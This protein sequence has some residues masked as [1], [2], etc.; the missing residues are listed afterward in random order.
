[1]ALSNVLF[2]CLQVKGLETCKSYVFRVRA[3]NASGIGVASTPSDP[4]CIKA[5]PGKAVL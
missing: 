3:E 4:V 5:L 2:E 1:M